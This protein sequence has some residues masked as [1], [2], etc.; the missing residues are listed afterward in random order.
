MTLYLPTICKLEPTI[1]LCC[2]NESEEQPL[3]IPFKRKQ[4]AKNIGGKEK[5]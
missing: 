2:K 4:I 1:C 5:R 3:Q